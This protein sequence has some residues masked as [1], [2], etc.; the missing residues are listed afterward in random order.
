MW[1]AWRACAGGILGWPGNFLK[2]LQFWGYGFW[3]G[4]WLKRCE[5]KKM[6][7][8]L[9]GSGVNVASGDKTVFVQG[10][11][12]LFK[13]KMLST[14][15][16]FAYNLKKCD[17]YWQHIKP[18][19]W[20]SRTC[21]WG[22]QV[23]VIWGLEVGCIWTMWSMALWNGWICFIYLFLIKALAALNIRC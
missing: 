9:D 6:A 12:T 15:C 23:D 4:F 1:N 2:L 21:I 11:N 10:Q 5:R 17:L 13:K 16:F 20:S 22:L 18:A 3:W 19:D 8:D 7:V 14:P